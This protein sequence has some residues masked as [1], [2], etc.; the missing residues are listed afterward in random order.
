[1]TFGI[2]AA[3]TG[4]HVYPGLAVGEAL[5]AAGVARSDVLFIG[6]S[7]LEATAA[8][9]AGFPFLEVELRGLQRRLTFANVGIPGVVLR[10]VRA[11]GRELAAR[12]VAALLGMGGYVSVPAAL[13]ARRRRLQICGRQIPKAN[14]NDACHARC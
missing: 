8:P 9:G 13:A 12:N 5:V 4:G 7:R 14:A 10:A 6:G 1:M 2:A 11:I 3:G